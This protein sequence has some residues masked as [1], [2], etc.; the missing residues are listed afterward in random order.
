MRIAKRALAASL[1]LGACTFGQSADDF[2]AARRP[3][4]VDTSIRLSESE[5]QG[6]LLE[7]RDT[8]LLVLSGG[9][10]TLVPYRAIKSARF[11]Q[12]SEREIG[13]ERTPASSVRDRLRLV[14]RF[15]QGI[16]PKLLDDLLA[17]YGQSELVVLER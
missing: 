2:H 12:I 13:N 16:R 9:Q 7:V 14:S 5:L 6:E 4:G 8:A 3:T 10:V 1:L 17:A 15:P 11:R